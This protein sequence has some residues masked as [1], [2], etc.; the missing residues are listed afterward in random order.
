M[1]NLY[2]NFSVPGLSHIKLYRDDD[3]PHKFYMMSERATIARD[4]SGDPM[5]TFLLYARD[6]D[7]LP[8]DDL[9]VQRGYLSLSTQAGVTPTEEEK[10]RA[11]L[12][13]KL[14][15]ERT[16]GYFYLRRPVLVE[17]PELGYPPIFLDD[18]KVEFAAL[19]DTGGGMVLQS[20]GSKQ[21]SLIGAN[22]ATM[23]VLLNQ[24]GSELYRQ[25]ILKGIFPAGVRYQ[26]KFVAVI[27]AIKIH[28][29]GHL[30]EIYE[31]IKNLIQI[32]ETHRK[33]GRVV[34][35]RSW[36]EIGSIQEFRT[37]IPSLQIEIDDRDF[38]E[39]SATG[40]D[41][42][43]KL[44]EMALAILQN[45]IIP[46][47]FK[48]PIA[49]MTDEQNKDK[50][51]Q[52]ARKE[53]HTDFDLTIQRSDTVNVAVNPNAQI[54]ELLTKAEID[55]H[56]VYADLSN[57]YF[58]ELD[59]KVHPNVNFVDDPVYALKVFVDYDQ[60]DELRNL[61]IK[62]GRELLFQTANKIGRFRQIMAKGADG[63]PKDS[64]NF[65]S[66][67][68]Y[69][70]TGETIRV[71]REGAIESRERELVIS[72][73]RLGFVKVNLVL[74]AQPETVR[75]V[76][77]QMRYPGSNSPTA[78]QRFELTREKPTASFFTYTGSSESLS[79][80]HYQLTYIMVDGQRMDLSEQSGQAET[81]TIPG[82]FEQ[83]ITT[84]F[85]AQADFNVVQKII[86]D[87]RYTDTTNDFQAEHHA[88]LTSNG[89]TS[90]WTFGLRN[91]ALRDF[92]YDVLIIFKNGA[93]ERQAT[94]K[95]QLGGTI[96][97][98][99]GALAAL[100][101]NII[102]SLIDWSKYK[103]VILSLQYADPAN[104]ILEE[105]TFTFRAAQS[106]DTTWHVLLRD[107][108]QKSF[109]YRIRYFGAD[110]TGN[111]EVSWTPTTDT[112]VV[113]E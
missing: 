57:P 19:G 56:T 81:L 6:A 12:R 77:V 9:D 21:P 70:D 51:L 40:E 73:R 37:R 113:I 14:Q 36:P 84:R 50:W 58:Q 62:R 22:T 20:S 74:G 111:H 101:V 91:P 67:I 1:L 43:K 8:P 26:L 68:V 3:N 99:I 39:S 38:R 64:Y 85:L 78:Q 87:A 75:A 88:E 95:H 32:T 76:E 13:Q 106:A 55:A 102:A 69:K 94:Q 11:F 104:N 53:E 16:R 46:S 109:Q 59:V 52:Y 34:Y 92:E 83:T 41:F 27:P 65:W 49:G 79:E 71:P 89:E 35:R 66:E 18:G 47:L 17:E 29:H 100:E 44:E 42:T 98:G 54:T 82:P 48:E 107:P 23:S 60:Q 90:P 24:E 72:Y 61:R 31:H 30:D 86:V 5:F 97:T 103:L 25:A 93:Q 112:L 28:I 63:A 2:D 105:K 96:S 110:S 108:T 33:D 7:R 80:Y 15:A 10:I 45:N 4:D